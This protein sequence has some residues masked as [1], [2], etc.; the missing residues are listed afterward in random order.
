M[1]KSFVT[2]AMVLMVFLDCSR[3]S[4]GDNTGGNNQQSASQSVINNSQES[5]STENS[6]KLSDRQEGTH[7]IDPKIRFVQ[8]PDGKAVPEPVLRLK[9]PKLLN[10]DVLKNVAQQSQQINEGENSKK[11]EK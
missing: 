3:C 11:E 6:P 8:T 9:I 2:L 10:P 4:K 1:V 7:I 5:N